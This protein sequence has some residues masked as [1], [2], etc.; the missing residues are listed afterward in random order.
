MDK[1]TNQR[2]MIKKA[3]QKIITNSSLNS[4][5]AQTKLGDEDILL[6]FIPTT[7]SLE[8]IGKKINKY[9]IEFSNI[10][11]SIGIQVEGVS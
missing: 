6:Y 1:I 8:I 9:F 10:I 5:F 11:I 2:I 3:N 4:S 7:Y